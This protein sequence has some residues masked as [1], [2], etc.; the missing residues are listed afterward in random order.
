MRQF[1]VKLFNDIFHN[2]K[3]TV[4][5]SFFKGSLNVPKHQVLQLFVFCKDLLEAFQ[6]ACFN[7]GDHRA[8][9]RHKFHELVAVSGL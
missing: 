6:V 3:L 5:Y 2:E 9:T 1:N 8:S 4:L 7:T